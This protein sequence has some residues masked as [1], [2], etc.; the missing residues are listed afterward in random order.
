VTPEEIAAHAWRAFPHT[1]AHKLSKGRYLVPP[2]VR[3]ISMTATEMIDAGGGLLL[4]EAPPRHSKSETISRW[5][6]TW[7]LSSFPNRH[8]VLGSYGAEL[9]ENNSRFVRN[10]LNEF[11]HQL[12]V[13]VASDSSA[14]NRWHTSAGGSCMGV[15]VGGAL[16][17]FGGHLI[18]LDDVLKDAEE[19]E[20][21]VMRRKVIDWFMSVAWTRREPGCLV[22]V[23]MTRWHEDDLIGWIKA[24][25]E[26][27]RIAR[28]LRFP[29]LAEEGD[30]LG[31]A[32]GEPLWPGRFDKQALAEVRMP[33]S[34]RWWN[35][36]FQQRPTS[37]EGAEIKKAWWRWYDELPVRQDQLDLR[38]LTVDATFRDSDGSDYVVIQ[39]WG[40]YGTRRY[41]LGQHRERMGFVATVHAIAAMHQRFRPSVT[42]IEAKANGDAIIEMLHRAGISG[43][44]PITPKASKLA[45][46]RAASPQIEAGDVWLPKVRFAEELVEEAAAF[47]LGKHDDMV[48]AMAQLLNYLGDMRSTPKHELQSSDN[49]WVS[50][51]I[52]QDRRREEYQ[53]DPFAGLMDKL[54]RS[55]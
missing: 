45:R 42:L 48:D 31:R 13:S 26:M 46:A 19:A 16:T 10:T 40:V 1:F 24:H 44:V 21:E 22:I 52:A 38:A 9:A 33:L 25:P 35:A 20:S 47:P 53:V 49:R 54:R 11:G 43:V 18:V 37:A 12:G 27:S 30:I 4:V 36:L 29:A 32:E 5:L 34:E 39:A 15:G 41:L 2:H 14:V 6:P 3:L 55:V 28:V 51:D 50:P 7:F 23:M 17:G 8:V